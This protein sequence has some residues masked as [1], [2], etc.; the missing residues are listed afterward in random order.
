[1]T[2]EQTLDLK[3]VLDKFMRECYVTPKYIDHN[4]QSN[5]RAHTH[6]FNSLVVIMEAASKVLLEENH[7]NELSGEFYINHLYLLDCGDIG[8]FLM[9]DSNKLIDDLIKDLLKNEHYEAVIN[10]NK[11]LRRTNNTISTDDE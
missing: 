9:D 2:M 10:L 5:K 3:K 4:R 8:V 1:M 6:Y 7:I 11:V